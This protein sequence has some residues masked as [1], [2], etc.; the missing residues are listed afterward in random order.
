MDY[1]SLSLDYLKQVAQ[2]NLATQDKSIS[3]MNKGF[4]VITPKQD[5]IT[6]AITKPNYGGTS[7]FGGAHLGFSL[8][9]TNPISMGIQPQSYTT[10][11]FQSTLPNLNPSTTQIGIPPAPK[12]PGIGFSN[13]QNWRFQG[14]QGASKPFDLRSTTTTPA[15]TPPTASVPKRSGLAKLASVGWSPY[16]DRYRNTLDSLNQMIS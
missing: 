14:F 1:Q 5:P 15:G 9:N 10:P 12:A 8:D 11:P 13:P 7:F 2:R 16:Q 4:S 3:A 6:A